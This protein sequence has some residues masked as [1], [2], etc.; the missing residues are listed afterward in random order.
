MTDSAAIV[1]KLSPKRTGVSVE[2]N[3]ATGVRP[4]QADK[5]VWLFHLGGSQGL[6]VSGFDPA[7]SSDEIP[8]ES[9]IDFG[10]H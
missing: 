1:E 6:R 9:F 5:M 10:G 4:M 7:S 8:F 3:A 2:V